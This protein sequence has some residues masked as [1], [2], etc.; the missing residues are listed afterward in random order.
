MPS[1]VLC[2]TKNPGSVKRILEFETVIVKMLQFSS[3][4]TWVWVLL[5][6]IQAVHS[7]ACFSP[8]L[9][10]LF[11]TVIWGWYRKGWYW[12]GHS[13]WHLANAQRAVAFLVTLVVVNPR[14][15]MLEE[16]KE[17]PNNASP[18]EPVECEVV[19]LPSPENGPPPLQDATGS[20]RKSGFLRASPCFEGLYHHHPPPSLMVALEASG[21]H[22]RSPRSH[23]RQGSP[24]S[25]S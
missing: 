6:H 11:L 8:S 13:A 4:Q 9:V 12:P 17:L 16:C 5:C 25:R 2:C 14:G 19:S 22:S 18:T 10:F 20:G 23:L 7:W 3:K 15:K 21:S 24:T 1:Y